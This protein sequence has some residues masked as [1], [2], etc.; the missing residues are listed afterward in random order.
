MPTY[1]GRLLSC[2]ILSAISASTWADTVLVNTTA[3]IT[4]DDASC[5]IREAVSYVSQ[6]NAKK[7]S[8]EA[9]VAIIN[10]T[11]LPIKNE[12]PK[13]QLELIQEQSKEP[14]KQN[15]ILI[16]NL[17][18]EIDDPVTGL[19]KKISDIENNISLK[20]A[21]LAS[22]R[23][24]GINGCYSLS[25]ED[26]DTIKLKTSST[27]Y[28]IKAVI[29]ISSNVNI[30]PE[31][32]ELVTLIK[33]IGSHGLFTIDDGVD[34][35]IDNNSKTPLKY[36]SVSFS[37]INLQGCNTDF[38]A[39]NGGIFHNN[40]Y[41]TIKNSKIN[42]GRASLFGGAIYNAVNALLNVDQVTFQ[43]NQAIDGAAIYSEQTAA[44]ISN[45]LFTK[46]TALSSNAIVTFA[47]KKVAII[48]VNVPALLNSTFSSNIGT[49]VSS[50]STL[51]LK[52]LTVVLNSNGVNFNNES[53]I[54]YNSIIAANEQ[55]DCTNLGSIPNDSNTYM[56]HNVYQKGC[57]L[58]PSLTAIETNNP[59]NIKLPPTEKIIADTDINGIKTEAQ[60]ASPPA[61]G[62]LCPLEYNGG[63]TLTHKPRL[64]AS[65]KKLADSPI[66]NQGALDDISYIACPSND[67]RGLTR[68]ICDIGAVELQGLFG[69]KQGLD[70][71]Y[72]QKATF[73]LLG[74]LGVIGDGE[75]L[76]AEQCESLFGL[77]VGGYQDGC[78]RI[79]S[80]PTKGVV[81]FKNHQVQYTSTLNNFHGFD[82]FT[83]A[84]TT[85][86]S[87]FS[88]ATND[89]FVPIDV[90]VV[91]EPD[92]SLSSKSL[93]TGATSLLSL[94]MLSLFMVWRRTR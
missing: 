62:L 8:N 63:F 45:S 73:D 92:G 47:E 77:L 24:Q 38:C 4:A 28:E 69:A 25:I 6:K 52:N 54:L 13:K 2:L 59:R 31:S 65:Y 27:A 44:Y 22:Y 17:A 16:A 37:D 82:K 51:T 48:G 72:G 12:L 70:I 40:E 79:V 80:Y 71:T 61:K 39:V 46:N 56:A 88:D 83:Y 50:R 33:A 49:A 9:E 30:I 86:I 1:Q 94:I 64:L 75:L 85:T 18:K 34:N 11:M 87:R 68:T 41:L 53:P 66:V 5:S 43:N 21:E 57:E 15:P 7:T 78:L 76:P 29:N 74:I 35:D 84:M 58:F 10:A 42:D 60:C 19:K 26:T 14:A 89:Q 67:Q 91:S 81:V 93:D 32:A 90:K 23:S 36:I 20:K 3:D 55:Q